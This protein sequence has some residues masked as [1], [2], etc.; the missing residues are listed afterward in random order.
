MNGFP[1]WLK[2]LHSTFPDIVEECIL[3]E[4]EWEFAQYDGN[5]MCHYVLNDVFWQLDWIKPKISERILSHLERYNPK[6]DNTVEEALS[7]VLSCPDCNRDTFVS[8]AK[9]KIDSLPNENRKALWLA[10]WICVEAE[11]ALRALIGALKQ[12]KDPVQATNFSMQFIVALIGERRER[13]RPEYQ[14][15]IRPEILLPLIKLMNSHIRLEDDICRVGGPAYTPI[16][17][18]HAQDNRGL[19]LEWLRNIPGKATYLALL[20]LAK[21]HPHKKMRSRCLV[22][23][24]RRAEEDA[25]SAP[26]NPGDITLFARESEKP[27]RNH[28]ELYDLAVSRL[29][30]LKSD[31]EDG[32]SSDAET[33]IEI[34]DERRHRIYIG[35]R[36]R[37]R[38][39]GHYSV[40]QEEELADRKRP[41]IRIHGYGFD[42]PVPIEL[43]VADKWSGAELVYS[44]RN[45]LCG[46]YLRDSRSDCGIFLMVYRGKDRKKWQK[47][48]SSE[49]LDFTGMVKLLEEETNEILQKDKKIE[50]ITIIG[51]D[52]TERIKGRAVSSK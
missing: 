45:Q 14:D 10:G 1:D 39:L 32:D 24:K 43:K 2:K 34:K 46:Q 48:G 8:I 40:P 23:A 50:S 7:I 44:L 49:M 13:H 38:A 6:H 19:L 36:L 5:E 17:R 26:W 15:Y 27:P 20:D 47:P 31:L 25:E 52:L 21:T 30:D 16:L 22:L 42:G 11:G 9:N 41:D 18:D 35:N 51:I 3:K 33:Y 37:D 12:T 29:L 4:I 28:R